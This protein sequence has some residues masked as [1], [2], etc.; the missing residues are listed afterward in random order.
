MGGDLIKGWI[1]E[2]GMAFKKNSMGGGKF[3]WG[4]KAFSAFHGGGSLSFLQT[5][6]VN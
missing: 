6:N 3:V 2:P 1:F 5:K 4:G